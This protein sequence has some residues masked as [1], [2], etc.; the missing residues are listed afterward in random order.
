MNNAEHY[1]YVKLHRALMEITV[2]LDTPE[3]EI[4]V[5]TR[6]THVFG[7]SRNKRWP[8]DRFAGAGF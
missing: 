1:I 4:V 5:R 6:D 8:R 3:G 7:N 2:K